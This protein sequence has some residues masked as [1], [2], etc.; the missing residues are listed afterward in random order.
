MVDRDGNTPL[1]N[2]C[3]SEFAYNPVAICLLL[4]AYPQAT[5]IQDFTEQST[6]LHLLLVLGGEVNM[7]C[8]RLIL[9]VAYSAVAG[10]R[11]SYIP[12]EDFC[13][14]DLTTN[15]LTGSKLPSN[16]DSNNTRS[17]NPMI[18]LLQVSS[19]IHPD[20]RHP[21]QLTSALSCWNGNRSF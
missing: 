8:V 17:R 1:H 20:C 18:L 12:Q 21:I 11:R 9:D 5:L 13:F 14:Q 16:C 4:I 15:L 7:T 10:L 19:T 2:A 3:A 6:P